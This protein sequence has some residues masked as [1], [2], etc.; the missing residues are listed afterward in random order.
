M[1]W[2]KRSSGNRYD[3]HSGHA[4]MIG[5]LS[6]K[7]VGAIVSSNMCRVCSLAEE[8][9]EEPSDHICPKNYDGSSKAMEADSALHLYKALFQNS[10][11]QLFLK[12]IVTDDDSSMRSL[13][14]HQ[15]TT[16]RKGTRRHA[17]TRLACGPIT[18]HQSSGKANL[19]FGFAI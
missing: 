2:N 3:S 13:L 5:C 15:K 16:K 11:K 7:I 9:G 19:L 1:G 12:A 8:N 4:L 6:K 18:L 17:S 10:K 14:K